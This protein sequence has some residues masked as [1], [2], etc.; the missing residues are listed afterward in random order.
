MKRMSIVGLGKL[1][2]PLAAAMAS[3]GYHVVGYDNDPAKI[4]RIRRNVLPCEP[5][6][7]E[8]VRQYG[9]RLKFTADLEA[10]RETSCTFVVVPTPSLKN[11]DFSIRYLHQAL[12]AVGRVLRHKKEFHVVAIVS[13][14]LPGSMEKLRRT[15][16]KSS[17][18]KCPGQIGLCYNPAFIAL[19]NVIHNFL[20]PDFILIGESDKASGETLERFYMHFCR[21]KAAIHRMNYSNAELAKI[22]VNTFITMKIS[23]GNMIARICEQLPDAHSE[24]VTR[25]IGSDRRI[26]THYLKGALGYGGPCFPRDNKAFS[27]VARRLGLRA[28]SA[29][30]TDRVNRSQI[31]WLAAYVLEK[32]RPNDSIAILGLSYKPDTDVIEESQGVALAQALLKKN[33]KLV[34]YDPAAM[35]EAVKLFEG[36]VSFARNLDEALRKSQLIVITTPW[37]EFMS[38]NPNNLASSNGHPKMVLDCWRILED[39]RLGGKVDYIPLGVGHKTGV[40]Q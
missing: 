28:H 37:K 8:L 11:G 39:S 22:A 24:T 16:E 7:D 10:I 18:K 20:H 17:G 15:L 19:G 25:A 36:K 38:L 35:P 14:V 5:H 2:L 4:E 32:V 3:R 33:R 34:L 1:G 23:F 13:T 30:A 9:K 40:A 29:E 26:G 6:L 27:F 31:D 12:K 21:S